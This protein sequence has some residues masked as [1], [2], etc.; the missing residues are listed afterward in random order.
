MLL[1]SGCGSAAGPPDGGTSGTDGEIGGKSDGS[2]D[3]GGGVTAGQGG[4][5][6]GGAAGARGG[7]AGGAGTAGTGATAGAGLTRSGGTSGSGGAAGGGA[8]NGVPPCD[9]TGDGL[10]DAASCV[11]SPVYL[12]LAN[13]TATET[14]D[15]YVPGATNPVKAGLEPYQVSMVGPVQAKVLDYEFR[16]SGLSPV[17]GQVTL[18]ANGRYTLVAY[19]DPT[20]TVPTLET[21]A[22]PQMAPGTCGAGAEVDFGELTSL[23]PTPVVVLYTTNGGTSW[24]P[25]ISP[26]LASGQIFGSGCWI[27][28][29]S[30]QFGAGPAKAATPTDR[31]Q[32]VTFTDTLTYQLLMT[33]DG[34]IEIDSLDHVTS[35]PKL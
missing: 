10:D 28:G 14:F 29:T 31:Y 24:T 32:A 20:T 18:A 7:A 16:A 21:T 30:I 33:D 4:V 25:A 13:A 9:T 3:S 34:I 19:L 17:R 8:G 5:G 27:G 2:S 35:V 11:T 22:A 23:T 26:G 12:R 6:G 15:V 1:L